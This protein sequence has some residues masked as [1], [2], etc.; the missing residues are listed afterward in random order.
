MANDPNGKFSYAFVLLPFLVAYVVVLCAM[1]SRGLFVI[2][3][4]TLAL[5]G[6]STAIFAA[7]V[8]IHLFI[9]QQPPGART[10]Q[11]LG[12]LAA[13]LGLALALEVLSGIR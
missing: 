5:G 12:W 4:A 13:A 8:G 10:L 6:S 9:S 7:L 3:V 1:W 2:L 11:V